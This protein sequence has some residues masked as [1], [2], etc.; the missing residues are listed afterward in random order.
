MLSN[1]ADNLRRDLLRKSR[2]RLNVV[3][4]LAFRSYF[5]FVLVKD[6]SINIWIDASLPWRSR[7]LLASSFD[8]VIA[9]GDGA[10]KVERRLFPTLRIGIRL[11]L[12]AHAQQRFG[13]FRLFEGLDL[14]HSRAFPRN[15]VSIT[16]DHGTERLL[17]DLPDLLSSFYKY[18]GAALPK[19]VEF[20]ERLFPHFLGS[21]GWSH[22]C[23]GL[24]KTV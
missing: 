1:T 10:P 16:T 5:A 22:I 14:A 4:M 15:V 21:L 3:C 24:I 12:S 11:L 20:G 17:A 23:D 6:V 2:I 7:E 18:I 8:L 13:K 9:Q 19:E